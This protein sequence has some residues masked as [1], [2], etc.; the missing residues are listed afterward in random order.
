MDKP[1][2]GLGALAG[3]SK[4]WKVTATRASIDKLI[5]QIVF[6]YLGIYLVGLGGS[7]TTLGL[8]N[9]LG[10]GL[11][12]LYGLVG[13]SFIRNSG[14]R[15]IYVR[16]LAVVA[17]SY[18]LLGVA[19]G[20]LLGMAGIMV[21]WLA[22]AESGL[23]CIVVCGGALT[24]RVRATAMG[25]CESVAQGSMSF[26]G[27]AIGAGIVALLGGLAVASIRPLFF[28]AAAGEVGCLLF[29]R[30]ALTDGRM[31]SPAKSASPFHI[32]K[33]RK[34]LGR[35]IAVACLTNLPTG[36]V[37]PFTQLFAD[38]QKAASPWVLGAMVTASALVS[39][40]LGVPL[41]KLADRF[42]R[43][44]VLFA[45]APVFVASNLLLVAADGPIALIASGV[46]LGVFPVTT[47]ISAAMAFEQVPAEDMGDWMA[48]LR[49]FKMALSA[50]L[51]IAAG[52]VWDH[53]GAKWVFLLAA[54]IDFLVRV[55]LLAT[56][57]ET[58][59]RGE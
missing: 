14:T 34:G 23:C 38:Q 9:G 37:L 29:V 19:N 43:K 31:A 26:I 42:G 7:G 52:L 11:S 12:A 33:K 1:S 30:A 4:N 39:L 6:P 27:P 55:P 18:L 46:L 40:V 32:L 49:F 41:G 24:N 15:K 48:I 57:P 21:D 16:G 28:I 3:L 35:F 51:T 56:I 2:G 22:F 47:V 58:L 53:L 10:M 54:G 13:A 8:A 17:L 50:V 5:Y 20:W 59:R 25:A 36:M 44:K 45:L